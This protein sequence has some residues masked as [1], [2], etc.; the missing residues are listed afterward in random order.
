M[1]SPQGHQAEIQELL[2]TGRHE[3]AE[4]RLQAICTGPGADAESWFFLGAILGMRGD[5]TGAENCFRQALALVPDF[6]Q[7]RFNLGIA[8]RDQGRLDEAR[9][10]LEVVIA[11]QPAHADA[12]NALGYVYFRLE[13]KDDAERLFRAALARNPLFADALNNLGNLLASGKRSAEAIALYR[14]ALEVAPGY[15]DAAVNL[16]AALETQERVEEA[17]AAYRLA[18]A[19]NPA[20]AEVHVQLGVALMRLGNAQEAEQAF[21]EALRTRPDHAEARYFLATLGGDACPQVAPA[22]YVIRLYDN[23]AETFDAELVGKLQ[24]RAPEAL[25]AAVQA[26]LAGRANLDVLDLGCGTG[27]CGPLFRPLARTLAGVDLSPKMVAKAR[28]RAVYDELEVGELTAALHKRERALD[29][30]IAADVL[31]YFGEL[32]PVF[33]AAAKALRPG[34]LF[35]FSVVV[36]KAEEGES[37]VLCGTGHYAHTQSFVAV[38]ASRYAFELVTCEELCIRQDGDQPILGTIHVLRRTA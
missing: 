1:H 33:E 15:G 25:L 9:A 34:G 29:L 37:Y 7:A 31:I 2:R 21:R 5:P 14:R 24:Y 36:A 10:E 11:V 8:L 13:R 35:A 28:S 17:I 20:S 32:A 26:V 23:Y 4:R 27:L 16:G 38:L 12:C 22:S 3:E 6:L 30:A 18:I 19:A